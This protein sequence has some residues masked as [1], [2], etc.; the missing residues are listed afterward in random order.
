MERLQDKPPNMYYLG[1][2]ANYPDPDSFLRGWYAQQGRQSR[3]RNE[4]YEG[5]VERARRVTD[6][7][8]RMKLYAQADRIIMEEVPIFPLAHSRQLL[9]LKPWVKRYPTAATGY[10]FLKDVILEPH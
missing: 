4:S 1:W 3:W 8:E 10:H 6:Q 5:L 7:A 2:G 9:L